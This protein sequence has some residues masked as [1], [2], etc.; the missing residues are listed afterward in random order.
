MNEWVVHRFDDGRLTVKKVRLGWQSHDHARRKRKED[1]GKAKGFRWLEQL[2]VDNSDIDRAADELHKATTV[3]EESVLRWADD[4][5][6]PDAQRYVD[7]V[8]SRQLND[9]RDPVEAD[10]YHSQTRNKEG[11]NSLSQRDKSYE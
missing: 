1:E 2:V 10:R 11:E 5:I 6:L 7:N 4:D 3:F 9:W 8:L